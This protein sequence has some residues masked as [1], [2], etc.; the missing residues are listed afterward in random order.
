MIASCIGCSRHS[1]LN[2]ESLKDDLLNQVHSRS[3][4]GDDGDYEKDGE[5]AFYREAK[6]QTSAYSTKRSTCERHQLPML[7]VG[8]A[9]S[10]PGT[11]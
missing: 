5:E 11:N 10:A 7:S 4:F 6:S 2:Q 9:I 8:S 1:F 3:V